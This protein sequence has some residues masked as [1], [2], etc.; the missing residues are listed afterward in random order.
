MYVE[1]DEKANAEEV[2]ATLDTKANDAEVKEALNLKANAADVNN[3][4]NLKANSADVEAALGLKAN[5]ADVYTKTEADSAIATAIANVDHLSREIVSVL[6]DVVDAN[7][8]IIY[9][10]PSG[11]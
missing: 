6:P 1:L 9:M 3:A 2:Q 8:N 4:L 5:A 7:P 11:L 10:V